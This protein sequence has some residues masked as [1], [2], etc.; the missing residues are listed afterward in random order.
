MFQLSGNMI[1]ASKNIIKVIVILALCMAAKLGFAQGVSINTTG[2]AAQNEAILDISS[3]DKGVLFPR[4]MTSERMAMANPPATF[5]SQHA[6]GLIV[7]DIDLHQICYWNSA[8]TDW[9]CIDPDDSSVGLSVSVGPWSDS[10]SPLSGLEESHHTVLPNSWSYY[11]NAV[12]PQDMTLSEVL[13]WNDSGSDPLRVGIFR[14]PAS[15]SGPNTGSVLV[16]QG[17]E[18]GVSGPKVFEMVSEPGETLDFT[19]GE[20]VCIGFAQGGTTSYMWASEDGPLGNTVAWKNNSDSEGGSGFSTNPQT[21][22]PTAIRLVMEF[23]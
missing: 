15:S 10:W 9:Q 20:L 23:Y 21:G 16:G 22:T 11:Y 5:I 6:D 19:A 8:I 1:M 4:V 2:L 14:G 3:T 7:F 18:G 12:V 13:M 17:T